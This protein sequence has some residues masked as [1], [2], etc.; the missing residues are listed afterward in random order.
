MG[1]D[2]GQPH[3]PA[4]AGVS[5]GPGA[6][7][8]AGGEPSAG[9]SV[10]E[11]AVTAVH[12]RIELI[13]IILIALTAVFT[14]WSAF[15]SS[16]WGGVMSIDFSAANAARTESVRASDEAN[17]QMTIDV[18]LFTGYADAL[19]AGEDDL[20]DFY[21]ERFP[22]RL[23]VAV[24]AWMATD[25]LGSP[26][27]PASPFAMDAYELEP[28]D[29]AAELAEQAD[30]RAADARQANQRGDNYTITSVFFASAILFAALSSKIREPSL[31][32]LLLLLATLIF[33][34]TA[35]V[36]ATYP[37]EI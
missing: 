29:E 26:D 7:M 5:D 24:D 35:V 1:D 13:S 18:G 14:A 20:A 11:R 31:G 21:R 3:D 17:R 33:V 8:A 16:K 25:P 2:R 23:G 30:R 6:G 36:I 9:E 34:G 32:V 15:E 12:D 10:G 19:A 22:E 4:D 28:A 37:V 27:A